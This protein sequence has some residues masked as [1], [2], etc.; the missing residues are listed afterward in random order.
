MKAS[1]YAYLII[2]QFEGLRLRSYQCQAGV[3]TIGYG[4][5]QGV[6]QGMAITRQQ[7]EE[8][9][10]AD[11]ATTEHII[12]IRHLDLNQNQFDAL[13][14]LVF[15]IGPVQ[16]A[17]STLLKKIQANPNDPTIPDEFRRWIYVNKQPSEGLIRRRDQEAKLYIA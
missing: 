9:L 10:K 12:N 5:T 14:S 2:Q 8:Y 4:H 15:N 13:V 17:Q 6:H 3:W 7:A 16:F 1:P 11:V